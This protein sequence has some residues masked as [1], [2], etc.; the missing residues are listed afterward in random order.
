MQIEG[1]RQPSRHAKSEEWS[2]ESLQNILPTI[3][4]SILIVF[5]EQVGENRIESDRETYVDALSEE[6]GKSGAERSGKIVGKRSGVRARA[7][8]VRSR[9][10]AAMG[11]KPER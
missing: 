2:E 11:E 9:T 10:L 5:H 8:R 6:R 1:N 4:E 7:R 3:R